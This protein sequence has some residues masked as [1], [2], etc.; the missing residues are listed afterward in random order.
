MAMKI[1]Q[2]HPKGRPDTVKNLKALQIIIKNVV[3]LFFMKKP[4]KKNV[5]V[6]WQRKFFSVNPRASCTCDKN[7]R[8]LWLLWQIIL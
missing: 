5:L 1:H 3:C 2:H 8:E 4:A 6:S 7:F